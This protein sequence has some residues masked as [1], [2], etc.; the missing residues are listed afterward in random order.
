MDG[1]IINFKAWSKNKPPKK[2]L[3]IRLQALGDTIITLPYLLDLAR[4]YPNTQIDFLTRKETSE[5]SR[6]IVLFNKVYTIGGGRNNKLIMLSALLLLPVLLF[7]KYDIVIDLQK[8]SVSQIIRKLL[9]TIAWSE[10]DRFSPFSAGLRTKLT[11]EAAGLGSIELATG[12]KLKNADLGIDKLKSHGWKPEID[13]IVLNP[14]GYF[15]TRN[16]PIENYIQFAELWLVKNPSTCFLLLGDGR[17]KEK[18]LILEKSLNDKV[19]NLTGKTSVIEAFSIIQKVKF[20]LTE[21]SGLMHMAWTSGVPTLAIFGS[22]RSDWSAPQGTHS[23][24]LNASDLECGPCMTAE[25]KFGDVHCLTR[26]TPQMV[27]EESMLLLKQV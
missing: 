27:F 8:N 16:W 7:Q 26:F 24:C 15:K 11:I 25:C 13:L 22:T 14:A 19:I 23:K 3:A 18:S 10:F 5:I 9:S 1:E 12:F 17:I 4:K 20:M 2:I 21:D 6:S